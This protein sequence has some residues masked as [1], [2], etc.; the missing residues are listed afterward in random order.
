MNSLLQ[1]LF[2]IPE[3]RKSILGIEVRGENKSESVLYQLQMLFAF[4]QESS[5]KFY[6]TTDFCATIKDY[7]GKQI[8]TSVQMDCNEF[9]NMLFDR[10]ESLLKPTPQ[11]KLLQR[12]FGGSLVNQLV[13][14]HSSDMLTVQ[15][16]KE[17]PHGSE[18]VEPFFTISVEV[19]HKKNIYESLDL[20]VQGEMLVGENKYFCE[21]CNKGVDTLKRYCIKHLPNTLLVH[22][23]RFEFDYD[24]MK[25]V[26]INDYCEFPMNLNLE[27]YTK[28]GIARREVETE[29]QK[30]DLKYPPS[31][32]EYELVGI[33]VH[34]GTADC[35]HYYSYIKV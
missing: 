23:K 26:K 13:S 18:T 24:K 6:D 20:F 12:I 10:L 5:K 30:V 33:V 25:H 3:F 31:Y 32:Y 27:P 4:L 8:N 17:C 29:G 34:M 16:C 11:E 1:Q 21:T 35:G 28:E 14:Y 19:S 2:L 15:I 22:L 7:E 9:S